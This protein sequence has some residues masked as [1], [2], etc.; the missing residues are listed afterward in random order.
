MISLINHPLYTDFFELCKESTQ[1]IRLCAPFVKEKI[2]SEVYEQ[3]RTS[4]TVELITN[5][6]LMNFYKKSIDLNALKMILNNGGSVFNYPK[7]H[8][9]FFIFD[10]RRVVI[11]SANLTLAGLKQNFEYGIIT[12]DTELIHSVI[13]DYK[14]LQQDQ[15]TG[16][17][18]TS[19]IDKISTILAEIPELPT[20]EFPSL[21]L[22]YE[23][24]DAVF[25]RKTKVIINSLSGWKKAVFIAIQRIH[26]DIFTT[27]D[28]L[29]LIPE[30]EKQYPNNHFIEAKIRQQLQE[31][32]DI[33][34][35]KFEGNGI[36]RKLW[37]E[38]P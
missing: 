30:L 9:K 16:K 15:I 37:I 34:L 36:Y 29:D 6:N 3:K 32:R 21:H 10:D 27:S 1:K 13:T 19:H 22:D 33:G 35:I 7:L 14:N 23:N 4:S 2:I 31:L 26:A 12:D 11:T 8:A 25:D 18:N 38:N 5:I 28:Y 17:I 24:Q 20:P